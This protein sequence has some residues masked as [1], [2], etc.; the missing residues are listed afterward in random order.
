LSTVEPA[1]GHTN[2]SEDWNW[3]FLRQAETDAFSKSAIAVMNTFI[4]QNG[5]E[6][7][8]E[9]DN[10]NRLKTARRIAYIH[11]AITLCVKRV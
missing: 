11:H 9:R 4:H 3:R 8:R 2:V 5:K 6:T 7:D 10:I 1:T